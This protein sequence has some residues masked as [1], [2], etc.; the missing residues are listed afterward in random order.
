MR[1]LLACPLVMLYNNPAYKTM[2]A[3]PLR[4]GKFQHS[5]AE[6]NENYL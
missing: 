5:L 2:Q 6:E 4:V 3:K 1:S